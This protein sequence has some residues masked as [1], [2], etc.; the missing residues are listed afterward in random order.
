[1]KYKAV[2]MTNAELN[3]CAFPGW[4][5]FHC[6]EVFTTIGSAQDHFGAD[7]SKK[8][9]CM[10]KVAPGDERGLLMELRKAEDELNRLRAE[11]ERMRKD[12]EKYRFLRSDGGPD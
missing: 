12:A 10:I 11:N 9:G 2:A 3:G 6:G 8:P 4:Q 1:M 7:P 5:C